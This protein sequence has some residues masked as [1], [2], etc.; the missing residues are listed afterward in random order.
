M[1]SRKATDAMTALPVACLA[2]D[3]VQGQQ[4]AP[5]RDVPVWLRQTRWPLLRCSH[6]RHLEGLSLQGLD[7]CLPPLLAAVL[8]GWC[9][10]PLAEFPQL[11][12]QPEASRDSALP[13]YLVWSCG[14]GWAQQG[15]WR[16]ANASSWPESVHAC[17]GPVLGPSAGYGQQPGRVLRASVKYLDSASRWNKV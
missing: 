7:R 11:R 5:G 6:Y 10:V 16:G 1:M 17:W 12:E 2:L 9:L 4:S 3:R 15:R 8:V 13:E 14:L